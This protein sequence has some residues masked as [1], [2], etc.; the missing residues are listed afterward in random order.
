MHSKLKNLNFLRYL[1]FQARRQHSDDRPNTSDSQQQQHK[2]TNIVLSSSASNLNKNF[3]SNRNFKISNSQ[4]AA[5]QSFVEAV[6]AL[7]KIREG[8]DILRNSTN[9]FLSGE[10]QSSIAQEAINLLPNPPGV[11]ISV[12]ANVDADE[13][14]PAKKKATEGQAKDSVSE[15]KVSRI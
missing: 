5:A 4:A 1:Y 13:E 2:T 3:Y 9:S 8:S 6:E 12:S 7:D 11:R 10:L 14:K 15:K